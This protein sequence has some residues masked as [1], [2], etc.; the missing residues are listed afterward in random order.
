MHE[1]TVKKAADLAANPVGKVRKR[2]TPR[3]ARTR[4]S[5]VKVDPRVWDAAMKLAKGDP[6]RLTVVHATEVV[7]HNHPIQCKERKS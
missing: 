3:K 5:R 4:V 7:V 2:H 1:S 6:S